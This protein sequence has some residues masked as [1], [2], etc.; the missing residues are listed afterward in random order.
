MEQQMLRA[1]Q[2][3]A[4]AAQSAAEAAWWALLPNGAAAVGTV[5]A[6]WFLAWQTFKANNQERLRTGTI[7]YSLTGAIGMVIAAFGME[8]DWKESSHFASQS[9]AIRLLKLELTRASDHVIPDTEAMTTVR[10]LLQN[11]DWMEEGA[12]E[13][14]FPRHY[15]A[16]LSEASDV[17]ERI[18]H[19]YLGR[20]HPE[21]WMNPRHRRS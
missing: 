20:R 3:A 1:A 8:D 18:S 17:F 14:D 15:L 4:W 11:V 9:G 13:G 16:D 6:L 19:R 12:A 2:E 21:P 10:Y 5:G 7:C